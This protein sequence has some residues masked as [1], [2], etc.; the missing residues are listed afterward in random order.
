MKVHHIGIVIRNLPEALSV[1][2]IEDLELSESVIDYEQNNNLHFLYL[3]QNDLW[4]ELVE[5]LNSQSTVSTFL[6][7]NGM[8]LHHIGIEVKE[9]SQIENRYKD[10]KG[11]F[12]LGGYKISVKSFGGDISTKFV[13]AKGLL[14]EFLQVG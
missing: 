14:L 2:E 1:L 4:I 12:M 10:K 13:H 7:R 3:P 8:A 5:P 9:L 11:I 6:K